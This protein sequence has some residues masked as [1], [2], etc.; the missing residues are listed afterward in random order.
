MI[1]LTETLLTIII[2]GMVYKILT[3]EV[4]PG[5]CQKLVEDM[6]GP[7]VFGLADGTGL[8]QQVWW[9]DR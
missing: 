5:S 9:S 4:L 6:E 2:I 7:L 8:L 3:F 1:L